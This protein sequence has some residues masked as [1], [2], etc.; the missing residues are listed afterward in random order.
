L[1]IE[2]IN[3]TKNL[4][5]NCVLNNISL[6]LES[7]HIYGFTGKNGSGKT[8]LMRAVCG[9]ITPSSGEVR[10]DGKVLGRDISFPESV[11]VLIENPGF[12]SS[13]SGFKNL[14]FLAQIQNRINDE[15]IKS[16][17]ENVGLDPED[18][19]SF[20]KYSLGMKQKLGIAAAIMEKP[21]LL[22]L[23]EPFNALDEETVNKIRGI[24]K[25]YKS[26]DHIVI[27]SCHDRDEIDSL[28]D[29]I[30]EIKSGAISNIIRTE[31]DTAYE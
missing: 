20:R 10:I 29:M 17:M 24:I 14:K 23:D 11:G 26:K 3:Y 12:T 21:K 6:T 9:L 1:K 28:C 31:K 5:H 18:K 25:S 4:S 16:A 8:M 30:I 15:D 7:G 27:L 19:K 2:I 13:F 22:I